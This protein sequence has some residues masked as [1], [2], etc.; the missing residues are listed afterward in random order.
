MGN[1]FRKLFGKGGAE[2]KKEEKK[3]EGDIEAGNNNNVGS[4]NIGSY[5]DAAGEEKEFDPKDFM[6]MKLENTDV[7]REP[8]R[9]CGQQFIVEEVKNSNIILMDNSA[10]VNVDFA[11]DCHI[12]IGPCESSV[13]LRDCKNCKV[14]VACQQLRLRDCENLDMLLYI[15][16][17][18][19]S[20]E[21][22]KNIRIGCFQFSYFSLREQ[23]QAAN[24]SPWNNGWSNVHDFT[25]KAGET[26]WDYLPEGTTAADLLPNINVPGITEEE[27][28]MDSLVPL[29]RGSRPRIEGETCFVAVFSPNSLAYEILMCMKEHVSVQYSFLCY[30]YFFVFFFLSVCVCLVFFFFLF[31]CAWVF[32]LTF[33]Y[34]AFSFCS[35]RLAAWYCTQPHD[36]DK[37]EEDTSLVSVLR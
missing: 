2:Q 37:V 27:L 1:I 31:L 20:I 33:F 4:S 13:F 35:F 28:Q 10:Q 36:G 16:A 29:T 21:S 22:S 7:I 32:I 26:H 19:P 23:F 5:D 6:A 14:V 17:G 24:L 15:G 9:I 25:E 11:E 18:Q 30:I 8:G 34:F 3:D 12:F